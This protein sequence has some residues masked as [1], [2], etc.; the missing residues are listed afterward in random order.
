MKR[1]KGMTLISM[2]FTMVMVIV[3]AVLLMRIVPVYIDH[4]TVAQSIKSLNSVPASSLTGDPSVD[5]ETLRNA[6]RKRLE[7]NSVYDFK[8]EQVTFEQTTANKFQA[9]LVY[10]V[11]KPLVYNIKL[12]FDFN[13][14]YQ[15][16]V[17]SEK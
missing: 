8:T 16:D 5:A 11:I 10:Q 6:L 7:I 12:L 14:I 9:K 13:D 1:Q 2:V 4:Y 15:V 3:A 17:G